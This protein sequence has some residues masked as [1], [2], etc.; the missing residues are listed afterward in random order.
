MSNHFIGMKTVYFFTLRQSIGKGYKLVTTLVA[1]LII[2]SITVGMMI[3]AKPDKI[4]QSPIEKVYISDNSGSQPANYKAYISQL[5]IEQFQHIVFEAVEFSSIENIVAKAASDSPKSIAVIISKQESEYDMEAFIPVDSVITKN[6]SEELL[7]VMSQGFHSNRIL[8]AGLS[9]DQLE[10]VIKPTVTS[11]SDI[12]SDESGAGE[13]ISLIA[14]MLF[15]LILY[16]MLLLYGQTVCKLVSTEKTSRLIETL[17]ISV[18][19]YALIAGKVLAVTTIAIAQFIAWIASAIAGLYIGNFVARCL[20]PEYQNSVIQVITYLRENIGETSLSLPSMILAFLFFCVGFLFYCVISGFAGCIVT[21]PE[22][23]P[24]S[25]AV[26]Q[27]P[28]IVS[29]I[30]A[31]IAPLNGSKGLQTV[32]RYIPFTSP[33]CVPAEL[34]I[35]NIGLVEGIISMVILLASSL[36]V[37]VLGGKVYKGLALYTGQKLTFRNILAFFPRPKQGR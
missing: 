10:A 37:I 17:L 23:I 2:L 4:T 30:F 22:D 25:Q 32:L 21:K 26:F 6:Q 8:Q 33:F 9:R 35:G 7:E 34:A 36:L 24:S 5:K 16:C 1:L 20:Y 28:I 3:S 15:S 14:P 29:W 12:G 13:I 11:F 18:R 27:F 31:F 19:P